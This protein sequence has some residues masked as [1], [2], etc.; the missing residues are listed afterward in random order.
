[1][2]SRQIRRFVNCLSLL[3]FGSFPTHRRVFSQTS[4]HPQPVTQAQSSNKGCYREQTTIRLPEVLVNGGDGEDLEM[5]NS[6]M[7]M[8]ILKVKIKMK[9][10]KMKMKMMTAKLPS[11]INVGGMV[12]ALVTA[13][14]ML[15]GLLPLLGLSSLL[16]RLRLL[17]LLRLLHFPAAPTAVAPLLL[18]LPLLLA[19]TDRTPA[20]HL[21]TS[22]TSAAASRAMAPPPQAQGISG[23]PSHLRQ[24]A[25]PVGLVHGA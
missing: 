14:M 8:M 9:K 5:T 11:C 21:G 10:V 23:S 6:L 17:L 15:L 22:S 12:L 7:R 2:L 4:D 24:T 3:V 13:V 20:V 16:L 19:P 18:L 25:T 1:M